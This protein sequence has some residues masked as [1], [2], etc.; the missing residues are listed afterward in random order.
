MK[1]IT[2]RAI[3]ADMLVGCN[4]PENDYAAWSS[5]T[6]YL[7][8]QRCISGHKI[9]ECLIEHVNADPAANSAGDAPKWIDLGATNR[10]R[11]FDNINGSA[12][13]NATSIAV[14]LTPGMVDSIALLGVSAASVSIS[15]TDAVDGTVYSS[16]DSLVVD[17]DV[18]DWYAYFFA[19]ITSKDSVV[20]TDMPPY[21]NPTVYITVTAGEGETASVGTLIL[22]KSKYLGE[23]QY[24]PEIGIV[25]YSKKTTDDFGNYTVLQRAFSRR[26]SCDL[27]VSNTAIRELYSILAA[28]RATPVVWIGVDASP[29]L[30]VYGFYKTFRIVVPYPTQ[31]ICTI[32]IEGLT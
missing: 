31:S 19:D 20:L 8:G 10:W 27:R 21:A 17:D 9:Y 30:T 18:A 2:P 5:S 28:F 24:S 22:G 11:M 29:L 25:D 12:T 4:V 14:A 13:T 15:M 6:T 32:E 3:T 23:T 1:I 26:F 7:V 16:T